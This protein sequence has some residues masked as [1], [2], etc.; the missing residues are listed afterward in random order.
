M[1][2]KC[3]RVGSCDELVFVV[4][5]SVLYGST[6]CMAFDCSCCDHSVGLLVEFMK[7]YLH[8]VED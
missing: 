3:T 1:S 6:T 7:L 2:W 5:H 4:F 8:L